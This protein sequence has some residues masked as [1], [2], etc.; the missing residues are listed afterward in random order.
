MIKVQKV[1]NMSLKTA[2]QQKQAFHGIPGRRTDIRRQMLRLINSVDQ[3]VKTA[4]KEIVYVQP[5]T[6]LH[7]KR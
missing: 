1:T 6:G 2:A 3:N 4:G 5:R 7:D